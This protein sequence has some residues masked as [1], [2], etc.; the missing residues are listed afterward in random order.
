MVNFMSIKY[1]WS[2]ILA[3]IYPPKCLVCRDPIHISGSLICTKCFSRISFTKFWSRRDNLMAQHACDLQPIIENA[4]AMLFYDSYSRDM[5]HRLKYRGEWR[6]AEYLGEIFG[7]Y[8]ARE[9]LYAHVDV[10]V[11]VPI[12][13]L[14]RFLRGYNQ[15]EYIARGIASKMG[16]EVNS[17]SLY[18][19]RYTSAQ[20]R[21][22]KIERWGDDSDIFRV[23]SLDRLR[24][25]HILLVDDVYTSGA[26]IHRCVEVLSR[27]L[28]ECRIS[29]ATVA[30][31]HEYGI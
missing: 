16:I 23:R 14:R 22:S 10:V 12:H 11:P 19:C 13:P 31:S 3:V 26:T 15:S 8:L 30:A 4:S 20:A 17:H 29:V 9:E 28:P 5:I 6:T 27:A 2:D 7:A 21:K 18:R 25:R 1:L 24:G